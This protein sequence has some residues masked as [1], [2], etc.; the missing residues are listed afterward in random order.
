MGLDRR[1]MQAAITLL[2]YKQRA[3]P[4]PCPQTLGGKNEVL[5]REATE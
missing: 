3:K 5:R 1:M 2:G 4:K